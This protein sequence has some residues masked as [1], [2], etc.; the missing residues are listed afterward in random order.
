MRYMVLS[1]IHSNIDA[2]DAVLDDAGSAATGGV[3]VLGDLVGYGAEPDLVVRRIRV[4]PALTVV[5][6]NHDKVVAGIDSAEEFSP[7]ARSSVELT[8][9]RLSAEALEYLAGLPK[10]PIVVDAAIE[11]CHGA[12]CN[13][14]WY[15]HAQADVLEALSAASRPVL[16]FG[17]THLP[18]AAA[19]TEDAR[20]EV[21][22]ADGGGTGTRIH[23]G[24]GRRCAI[25]PGS[26]GQ[27]R[28]GD[29]RAAYGVFDTATMTMEFRRV[30]YAV[31]R[32][33][34]RIIAAGFPTR[35]GLRLMSGT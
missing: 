4:L 31:E 23:L 9:Q 12:P 30:S 24:D 11:I 29:P 21:L 2:L 1:D 22:L 16:L 26:V 20:L 10:G 13:E 27:P 35:L 34:D 8:R 25:N 33:R 32:A 3:I 17:H 5:R 7:L 6:G 14:D 28:D 19:R 15:L 18:F